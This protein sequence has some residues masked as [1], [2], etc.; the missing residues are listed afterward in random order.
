MM[1]SMTINLFAPTTRITAGGAP[2]APARSLD[3]GRWVMGELLADRGEPVSWGLQRS[4]ASHARKA[5]GRGKSSE[6][7]WADTQPWCHE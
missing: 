3:L 1:K 4:S 5:G 7:L 2:G 6:P